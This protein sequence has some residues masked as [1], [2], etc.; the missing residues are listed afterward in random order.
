VK[1]ATFYRNNFG[2]VEFLRDTI[3]YHKKLRCE[4]RKGMLK[5]VGLYKNGQRKGEW[6]AFGDSLRLKLITKY[7]G[8]K[9]DTVFHPTGLLIDYSW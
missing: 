2:K 8:N 3:I 5:E 1:K 7:K 4:Y 9:I 6:F